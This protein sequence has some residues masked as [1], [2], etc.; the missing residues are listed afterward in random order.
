MKNL[1]R[2]AGAVFAAAALATVVAPAAGAT[3][4]PAVAPA[5]AVLNATGIAT[6]YADPC[7]FRHYRIHHPRRCGI[8][9]DYDN[10]VYDNGGYDHN[11]DHR[12]GR[13][14]LDGGGGSRVDNHP[15]GEDEHPAAETT[16]TAGGDTRTAGGDTGGG[17]RK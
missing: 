6:A 2:A 9:G 14:S 5:S 1:T 12:G 11:R 15:R 13:H 7:A 3:T 10:G 16:G 4:T 8:D 17:P